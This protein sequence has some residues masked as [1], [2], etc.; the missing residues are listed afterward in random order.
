[1]ELCYAA[2]QVKHVTVELV[3]LFLSIFVHLSILE[4]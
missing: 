3:E 2:G 1:M 4:G